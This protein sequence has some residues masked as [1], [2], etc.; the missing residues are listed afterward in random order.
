MEHTT[1]KPKIHG[2]KIRAAELL[3]KDPDY[4]RRLGRKGG[5]AP[6]NGPRGFQAMSLEQIRAAGAKGGRKSRKKDLL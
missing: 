1:P 5:S 6:H 3:A 4:F 2:M